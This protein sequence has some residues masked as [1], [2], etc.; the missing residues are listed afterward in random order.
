MVY[1]RR[2]IRN[3]SSYEDLNWII[4]AGLKSLG[5]IYKTM[6][7]VDSL[8]AVCELTDHLIARF[9][10]EWRG[11]PMRAMPGESIADFSAVLSTERREQI[12]MRFK[13]GECKILVCTEAAGMGIDI[14][15]VRRVIQWKASQLLNLSSFYQR[16][17]RAGR[18]IHHQAIA[19]L[20][21]QAS[22]GQ[23]AGDYELF[24]H[25]IEGPRGQEILAAI[26]AFDFGNDESSLARKGRQ[27]VKNIFK[28][29][30]LLVTPQS[31]NVR[32][33]PRKVICRGI[34]TYIGTQGCMR[35]AIMKYFDSDG[36]PNST[37][38]KCCTSCTDL[39]VLDED[40]LSLL[41]PNP[42]AS[43]PNA[44]SD[45]D[46]N[47]ESDKDIAE[48]PTIIAKHP[49]VFKRTTP[50]QRVAVTQELNQ[51]RTHLRLSLYDT[52]TE[53]QFCPIPPSFFL[54]NKE[55]ERLSQQAHRITT[56]AELAK[57]LSQQR[58]YQWAPIAPY[59]SQ[60]IEIISQAMRSVTLVETV[61]DAAQAE[62]HQ[63]QLARRRARYAE[64]KQ[65]LSLAQLNPND[66]TLNHQSSS[67]PKHPLVIDNSE[68]IPPKKR[69]R[70]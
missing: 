3:A 21:Y 15:D 29:Q 37:S 69:P 4:P 58:N 50:E 60:V 62:K 65:R 33:D 45:E 54:S 27:S 23:L 59:V 17:G 12:L 68:N 2:A 66:N 43:N 19:I 57:R 48:Q 35:A 70:T 49:N 63:L 51:F 20:Y 34:L 9:K 5:E 1:D 41:P 30:G 32:G 52:N 13:E 38:T 18:N 28:N 67:Q 22:L 24:S 7:F 46:A 53:T 26:R 36:S 64:R 16:S 25:D 47:D 10:L 39:A 14:G 44:Q 55:I 11:P 8:S 42:G 6:I 56:E 40:I 61:K 31:T